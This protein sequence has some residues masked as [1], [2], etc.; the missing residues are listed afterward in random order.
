MGGGSGS[1]VSWSACSGAGGGRIIPGVAGVG[2][3]QHYSY[4]STSLT[5]TYASLTINNLNP[6]VVINSL[7]TIG[8]LAVGAPGTVGANP[9]M[10]GGTVLSSGISAGDGTTVLQN[11]AAAGAGGGWGAAG[12]SSGPIYD[13]YSTTL[14]T[15]VSGLGNPQ[16]GGAGGKAINTNGHAVTWIGGAS[17]AYGA[18]G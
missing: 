16:P 9:G 11:Y 18:I 14:A 12:G 4:G 1:D 17:R 8:F 5:Q 7:T 6:N 13:Y 2:N 3:N 15:R 10:D